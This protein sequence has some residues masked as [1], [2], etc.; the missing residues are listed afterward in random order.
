VFRRSIGRPL[1]NPE[2]PNAD[3]WAAIVTDEYDFEADCRV[4][5]FQDTMWLQLLANVA[6]ERAMP[7][8]P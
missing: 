3:E 6:W 4:L 5:H 2:A 1:Y 7:I 8:P